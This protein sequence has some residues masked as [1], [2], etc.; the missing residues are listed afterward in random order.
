MDALGAALFGAFDEPLRTMAEAHPETFDETPGEDRPEGAG[1][2]AYQRDYIAIGWWPH[3]LMI[4]LD[5]ATGRLELPEWYDEGGPAAY[6]NRDLSALLYAWWVYERLRAEWSRWD[7]G[8]AGDTW[9]VF[10]P[11]A[12][13]GSRVDA[14]VEAVDPE[15]FRTSGHSWRM[16]AEDPYTGGL[17]SD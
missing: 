9:Q 11:P 13:L 3:D 10:D 7:D 6:L 8:V 14:M 17:L 15:A 4:A 2:R 12:L 1:G 5:G 16:L